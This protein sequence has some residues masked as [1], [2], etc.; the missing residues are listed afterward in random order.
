MWI[1]VPGCEVLSLCLHIQK[2][3]GSPEHQ[4]VDLL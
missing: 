1:G 2:E 4:D 3:E